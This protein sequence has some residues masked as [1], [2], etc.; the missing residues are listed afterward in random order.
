MKDNDL[1]FGIHT[2]KQFLKHNAVKVE[3]VLLQEGKAAERL[4]DELG[5]SGL[6]VKLCD[7]NQ[8][9]QLSSGGNHQGIILR[10]KGSEAKTEKQLNAYIETLMQEMSSP[11]I[12][13]LDGITD[14]HNLGACLRSAAAAKVDAVIL[15]KDK[16]AGINATVRKVAAGAVETLE[17]FV[18][19]NLARSLDTLKSAGIWIVGTALDERA[20]DYY[21]CDLK[22]ALAI[23]MGSEGEGLRR[24]T[25]DKCDFLCY[26]PMP[27]DIQSL[28]VS[29]ATGICLF[30]A[31]RQRQV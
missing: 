26:L 17:I 16:S 12:L 8:L 27:G 21:Q 3:E 7:K 9:D 5:L 23:A 6:P 28:N 30:E 29:V 19:T 18:V 10:I 2:C 14:P 20:T 13:V 22:G 4:R 31:V 11:L 15:P 1:I 25:K 24:L